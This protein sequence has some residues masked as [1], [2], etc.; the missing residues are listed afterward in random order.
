MDDLRR[1]RTILTACLN[2]YLSKAS[3]DPGSRYCPAHPGA[4]KHARWHS[5]GNWTARVTI[6]P[7]ALPPPFVLPASLRK[8]HAL[9]AAP[10]REHSLFVSIAHAC[11]PRCMQACP[12]AQSWQL[13]NIVKKCLTLF[14]TRYIICERA[15]YTALFFALIFKCS[16]PCMKNAA[17]PAAKA[18]TRT[19]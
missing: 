9:S 18:M 1:Q 14:F 3:I 7:C 2:G 10:R 12:V 17:E 16:A 15:Q 11:A 4:C 8:A 19:K 13:G 6:L 5:H